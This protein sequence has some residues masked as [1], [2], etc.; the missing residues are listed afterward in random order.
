MY[1]IL[2]P[3]A[4][5]QVTGIKS[6]KLLFAGFT[7]CKVVDEVAKGVKPAWSKSAAAPVNS[8]SKKDSKWVLSADID[9]VDEDSLLTDNFVA[10]KKVDCEVGTTKKA[11]K[12]CTCGAAD[13]KDMANMPTSAC[14]SVCLIQYKCRNIFSAD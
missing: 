7:D 12:D 14:G 4:V 9:L 8:S 11:C 10:K 1:R 5:F 6:Q 13:A 2:E 3:G